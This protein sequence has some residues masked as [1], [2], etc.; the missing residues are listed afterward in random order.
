[1]FF[2]DL[3]DDDDKR[4]AENDKLQIFGLCGGILH[5]TFF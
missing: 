4:T 2:N 3:N 5:L 1:M